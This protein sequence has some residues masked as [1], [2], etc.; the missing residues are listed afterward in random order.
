LCG[1]AAE[2]LASVERLWRGGGGDGVRKRRK[3]AKRG[4]RILGS[5]GCV[6]LT[7]FFAA[8]GGFVAMDRIE[9]LA[10]VDR[11]FF[12]GLDPESDLVSADLHDDDRNVIVDDNTF[13]LFTR[14]NQHPKFLRPP[15]RAAASRALSQAERERCALGLSIFQHT[16]PNGLRQG[17]L[18]KIRPRFLALPAQNSFI[19]FG[20]PDRRITPAGVPAQG[21]GT[22]PFADKI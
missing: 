2:D 4:L 20:P 16:P 11:H 12:R 19:P 7:G 1:R 22:S 9:D 15:A 21:G 14:E 13:V 17:K 10:P 18:G 6:G 5:L 8:P 3:G